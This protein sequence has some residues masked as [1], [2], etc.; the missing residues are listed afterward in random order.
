[1]TQGEIEVVAR[2][3]RT[4]SLHSSWDDLVGFWQGV[5][6]NLERAYRASV[7]SI[8]AFH[9]LS[10]GGSSDMQRIVRDE[11]ATALR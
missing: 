6:G 7:Q 2:E 5:I 9:H 4:R 3:I 8:A 10:S 1:M 11:L